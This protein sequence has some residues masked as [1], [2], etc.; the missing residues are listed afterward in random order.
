MQILSLARVNKLSNTN[1]SMYYS[2]LPLAQ[3]HNDHGTTDCTYHMQS[4]IIYIYRLFFRQSTVAE[5]LKCC[6]TCRLL[7]ALPWFR[8]ESPQFVVFEAIK[9]MLPHCG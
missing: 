4:S 5:D 9:E 1:Y 6:L 8:W 3:P 7:G 2:M